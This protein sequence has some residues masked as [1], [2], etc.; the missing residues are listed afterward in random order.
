MA[1]LNNTGCTYESETFNASGVI[2][3]IYKYEQFV[4]NNYVSAGRPWEFTTGFY[5][6]VTAIT[7]IGYGDVA[8]NTQTGR[9]VMVFYCIIGVP[10]NLLFLSNFGI[11]VASFTMA[12]FQKMRRAVRKTGKKLSKKINARRGSLATLDLQTGKNE[13]WRDN[14]KFT[15]YKDPPGTPPLCT[16]HV[17]DQGRD[18]H[19]SAYNDNISKYEQ[20]ISNGSVANY[21]TRKCIDETTNNTGTVDYGISDIEAN[22]PNDIRA[23]IDSLE[24]ANDTND[25][26]RNGSCQTYDNIAY[27]GE[28]CKDCANKANGD[29]KAQ[30]L[31]PVENGKTGKPI[32]RSD[33]NNVRPAG[34]AIQ[35]AHLTNVRDCTAF[36]NHGTQTD[37]DHGVTRVDE[38]QDSETDAEAQD[39]LEY[40][41]SNPTNDKDVDAAKGKA[42]WTLSTMYV[43]YT[44]LGAIFFYSTETEWS[45]I[46]SLYCTFISLATI[47]FGDLIPGESVLLDYGALRTIV[48]LLFTYI[49]L[50]IFSAC[51]ALSLEKIRHVSRKLRNKVHI[52]GEGRYCC[53]C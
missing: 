43:L 20:S 44:I 19:Y 41:I 37:D 24:V 2:E 30:Y 14:W 25:V 46:D 39:H 5:L 8:P 9:I 36:E 16:G 7:T 28:Q 10:L 12:R 17:T 18:D 1:I 38:S 51:F 27:E 26:T 48:Y 42:L 45:F 32:N 15:S 4:I 35:M 49:G 33:N 34:V 31:Q 3:A 50:I 53:C 47:G 52:T 22:A 29:V 23:R 40:V 11:M 6:C 13:S 21:H